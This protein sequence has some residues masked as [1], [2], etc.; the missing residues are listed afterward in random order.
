M[1]SDFPSSSAPF[2]S[3]AIGPSLQPPS[4]LFSLLAPPHGCDITTMVLCMS[5]VMLIPNKRK[6]TDIIRPSRPCSAPLP[7]PSFP[8]CRGGFPD[9]FSLLHRGHVPMQN[10]SSLGPV[11]TKNSPQ[12]Y[13][14]LSNP[15]M[16][17]GWAN[18]GYLS[19]S[20]QRPTNM[21]PSTSS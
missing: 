8:V 3:P 16:K 11:L 7:C 20:A 14:L 6:D 10:V 18:G 5:V 2:H 19:C 9:H 15:K 4:L 13:V 12:S 21:G 17:H 1:C